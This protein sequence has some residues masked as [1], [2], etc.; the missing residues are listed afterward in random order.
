MISIYSKKKRSAQT[1]VAPQNRTPQSEP[2]QYNRLVQM[3]S[4][5]G[6]SAMEAYLRQETAPV[7]NAFGAESGGVELPSALRER[8]EARTKVLLG[9][10]RVHYNSD[11]PASFMARAFTKGNQIYIAP[12]QEDTLEHEVG[13][14]VQ[15]KQGR[16]QA[17]GSIDGEAVNEDKGLEAEPEGFSN[18]NTVRES[19]ENQA[20]IPPMQFARG[21]EESKQKDGCMEALKQDYE[22]FQNIFD[23]NY[24]EN[25]K[26]VSANDLGIISELPKEKTIQRY[27][28]P[29]EE[30]GNFELAYYK[31]IYK[32]LNADKNFP[33]PARPDRPDSPGGWPEPDD[34]AGIEA[35]FKD[36]ENRKTLTDTIEKDRG[37]LAQKTREITTY[38]IKDDP[39]WRGVYCSTQDSG[40]ESKSKKKYTF[41]SDRFPNIGGQTYRFDPMPLIKKCRIVCGKKE[42]D[43]ELED[44]AENEKKYRAYVCEFVGLEL[45]DQDSIVDQLS[46]FGCIYGDSKGTDMAIPASVYNEIM[47]AET[48]KKKKTLPPSGS[49][50][51]DTDTID[52]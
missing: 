26:R 23:K 28:Y 46:R 32:E 4:R 41:P 31:A 11:K 7:S 35:Y 3:A 24:I 1:S 25:I 20:L 50:T 15:Q 44:P 13:H 27:G 45:G 2:G 12:G 36:E 17:T 47:K 39:F 42:E 40:Y 6:N 19:V 33:K 52:E 10:V 30:E 37:I 5:I 9:D 16:V 22:V 29:G 51:M 34:N 18:R 43:A 48:E 8:M 14:V 49:Q 21:E 38:Y